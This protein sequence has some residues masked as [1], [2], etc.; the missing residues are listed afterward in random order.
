MHDLCDA[1]RRITTLDEELRRRMKNCDA[2]CRTKAPY[3]ELRCCMED[4]DA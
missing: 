1:A 4:Y 2:A 3:E